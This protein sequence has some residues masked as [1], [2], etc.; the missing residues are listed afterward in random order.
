[1]RATVFALL[2]VLAGLAGCADRGLPPDTVIKGHLESV[3]SGDI[4]PIERLALAPARGQPP[5]PAVE[6]ALRTSLER[7]RSAGVPSAPLVLRYHYVDVPATIDEA[8]FGVGVLGSVGSSGSRDVGIGLELPILDWLTGT[9]RQVAG[10][11]FDLTLTLEPGSGDPVWRG[12]AGGISRA[13]SPAAVARPLVPL[14]L[15]RLGRDTPRR[16]FLR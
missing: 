8:A 1:M 15:D 11:Q 10:T 12:R 16:E 14:L 5:E 4:G 2:L 6:E 7:R 3:R 13:L 9:D